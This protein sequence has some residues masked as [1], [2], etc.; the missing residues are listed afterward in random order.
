MYVKMF[1]SLM[2]EW[3]EQYRYDINMPKQQRHLAAIF[4]TA[5]A[6]TIDDKYMA[7]RLIRL[8]KRMVGY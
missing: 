5:I 3:N 6:S 7:D 2:S 8:S 1:H 4:A